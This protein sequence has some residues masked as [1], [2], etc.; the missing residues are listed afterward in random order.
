M[1]ENFELSQRKHEPE[2]MPFVAWEGITNDQSERG[3]KGGGFLRGYFNGGWIKSCMLTERGL[4]VV[5][6]HQISD[7]SDE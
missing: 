4:K 3:S 1:D 5:P 7:R 6:V 2:G